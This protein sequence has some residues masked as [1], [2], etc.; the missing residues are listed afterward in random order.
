MSTVLH[1]DT[2]DIRVSVNTPEYSSTDYLINPNPV[3]TQQRLSGEVPKR[4][5]KIVDNQYV[6]KTPEEIQES[7]AE[8]LV[9]RK[10]ERIKEHR[11]HYEETLAS[12]YSTLAKFAATNYRV[13]AMASMNDEQLEYLDQLLIWGVQG[14]ELVE[15]AES[16][17]E[18]CTTEE[19][20]TSVTLDL[21][22][23]LEN[24]P[25]VSTRLARKM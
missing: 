22:G 14:D 3:L 11:L 25:L 1:R 23:W 10:A 13:N 16:Q 7:D 9:E 8:Y 5:T 6:S 2:L 24:D 20:L 17:V 15:L 21:S 4:H 19:E 12:R 18:S